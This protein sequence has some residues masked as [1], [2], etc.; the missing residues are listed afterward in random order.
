MVLVVLVEFI[1]FLICFSFGVHCVS[2]PELYCAGGELSEWSGMRS[3]F[4]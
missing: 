1:S 3:P 2:D 4:T